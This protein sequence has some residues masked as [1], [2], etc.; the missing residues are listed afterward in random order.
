MT[1][2]QKMQEIKSR[3]DAVV[4]AYKS[5]DEGKRRFYR[6]RIH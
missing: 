3:A 1:D 6:R 5:W 2:D 4:L